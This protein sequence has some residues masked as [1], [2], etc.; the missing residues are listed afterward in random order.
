MLRALLST[1]RDEIMG[2]T[3]LILVAALA[4]R[5]HAI[6]ERAIF[7]FLEEAGEALRVSPVTNEALEA[8]GGSAALHGAQMQREG[9]SLA[10]VVHG[11]ASVAR[12]IHEL[13]GK[14]GLTVPEEDLRTLRRC[15]EEATA[16]AVT[17][18]ARQREQSFARDEQ[19]RLGELAHELRSSL[20]SAMISFD[21]LRAGTAGFAG[22]TA[23]VLGRSLGRLSSLVEASVASVRVGA[24]M[25]VPERVSVRQ[26]IEEVEV[27]A[28]ID[29]AAHEVTLDVLPV[30]PEIDVEV[31]RSI[32]TTALGN[33]LANAVKFTRPKGQVL[34]RAFSGDDR[35]FIEVEDE[36]G[37]LPAGKAE[38]LFRP[39]EQRSGNRTGLG[40]GLSLS[41]KGIEASG[42]KMSVRDRP[43]IGCVFVIELPRLTNVA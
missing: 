32:L 22:S 42:G 1:Q 34:L 43:G 14:A 33:L 41:R 2:Q 24:G 36:C 29:A 40:L 39:F 12:A 13:A 19:E 27:G 21:L 28:T 26:F 35:V 31:D 6:V 7:A 38:A 3:R 8:I 25:L 37:G 5:T 9:Y 16:Q 10:D 15:L 18:H 4:P 17:E 11:Y 30:E 20:G 23:G